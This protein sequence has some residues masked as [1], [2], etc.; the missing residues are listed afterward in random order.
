MTDTSTETLSEDELKTRRR[1]ERIAAARTGMTLA[2]WARQ[3]PDAPAIISKAGDRTFGELNANA[4]RVA[5]ALRSR[6]IEAG[7]SVSLVCSNRPEFPEVLAACQRIGVRLTPVNWHL[8]GSEMAYIIEDSEAKAV[9]ADAAFSGAV[10]AAIKELT[11]AGNVPPVLLAIGGPIAG[12][13]DYATAIAPEDGS[14]LPDPVVGRSMLYTSGTTGRPKGV[15]R[16]GGA[17]ST[18]E[19]AVTAA[20]N[21]TASQAASRY[22]PGTD[23]HLCTGPLYHAAPL[24]FSLNGPLAAGVGVVVMDGWDAVEALQLIERHR[25]T[26]THMV[27]TMFHRLLAVPAEERAKIDTSSLRYVIHGAAPCP[28]Q[29]KKALIDWL[30]PV[31]Y[32]YY[33]ATEGSGS[34]VGPEDWLKKPGTV[35]KPATDD[36]VRIL[37]EAGNELPRNE[38]GIIY[39]KAPATGRFQYYKDEEKT[40]SSYL[41]DEG[42]F[43]L[44]DHGYLDD[45]G[46]LF[47]TG[48]SAELIISGGVNIYPAEVDAVLLTHPAVG[49]V[50]VIGI[51]NAD[52]GEEVKA[53]V[54]LKAGVSPSDEL[55]AELIEFCRERLAHYKCPR[56]VDFLGELPRHDNGKLY[57][58]KLR[59]LYVTDEDPTG[60][61]SA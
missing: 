47:L 43:T 42:Y 54:E 55:A 45:E 29:V 58:R 40:K 28:V 11:A 1:E 46:W 61:R 35:G 56:T 52:W 23:L 34:F 8:T 48:R 37:D 33:A 18:A 20:R 13:E 6:G 32:E 49:D 39:L 17:A 14:D 10:E 15:D 24:A 41:G 12:F 31:V 19:A 16:S 53:V 9:F 22:T 2:W 59:D 57:R 5:R 50:G 38:V 3:Q 4:N 36:H 60:H 25:I 26:H 27:P 30:G 44:G 51:P 7:D 21:P